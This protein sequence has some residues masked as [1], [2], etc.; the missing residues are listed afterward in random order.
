M[1]RQIVLVLIGFLGG[2]VTNLLSRYISFFWEWVLYI[3]WAALV[4]YAAMTTPA[5]RDWPIGKTATGPVT[6]FIV[7]WLVIGGVGVRFVYQHY[8]VPSQGKNGPLPKAD[9]I[10]TAGERRIIDSPQ[11]LRT[12]LRSVPDTDYRNLVA[13]IIHAFEPK[14][15]VSVSAMTAGP[16]GTRRIDVLVTSAD[17]VP[18]LI[19][20]IDVF[21]LPTDH[22][23]GVDMVD[24][25]D[26]KRADIRANAMLICSNT[27]FD[28]LAIRKAK[29]QRI[30]LI[31][32]LRH[33]DDRVKAVITEEIYLSKVK[34]DPIKVSY[35]FETERDFNLF[36]SLNPSGHD[37][38]YRGKSVDAWLQIRAMDIAKANPSIEQSII[39]TFKLKAP[40]TFD[41]KGQHVKLTGLSVRFQPRTQWLSQTVQI[42]ATQGIYDYVRGRARLAG[43]ANSYV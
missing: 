35:D 29:R 39:A 24:A 3:L 28:E 32:V 6:A 36:K 40:T 13:E 20:A 11:E 27:G 10:P 30:G 8:A 41:I 38:K 1:A 34:L 37:L 9:A 5:V 26:S 23:V 33:G 22:K 15:Y 25:A 12:L 2:I 31:S 19:T 17:T 14:A 7:A 43:G 18:P 42:N 16:D 21:D 4:L